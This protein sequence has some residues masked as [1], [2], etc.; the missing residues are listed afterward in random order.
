MPAQPKELDPK[1]QGAV[2]VLD[3]I[4][5]RAVARGASDIHLEPKHD[6][7]V[8]RMRIDGYMVPEQS[9]SADLSPLVTSRVKVLAR[10]DIAERR[11]PQDGQLTLDPDG[12][13]VHLRAS[14][15]PCSQ[16]EKVVLRVL[17]GQKLI[18]FEQLGMDPT[19]MAHVRDILARPQ[20]FLV[21]SGPT[22]AGKTSTLYAFLQQIDTARMNVMTLEDPIEVEIPQITQ[23]QTHARAGFTFAAGL[24]AI[25]RQDPDVILVGEMRDAETA[26]IAL[27]A[28][29]TGHLVMSTL[30]TSDTVETVVRLVDLGLEPWVIANALSCVLAQRLVRVVCDACRGVT[31]LDADLCDG[32]EVLLPAG[33]E[34]IRPHGCAKCFKTGYRGRSGVFEVLVMDDELRDLVK[35]KAPP[36]SYRQALARR[37]LPT[38]RRVAFERVHEGITTVDEV[39]RVT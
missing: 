19:T 21:T 31:R 18:P 39:L 37:R 9:V 26:A 10:M 11:V 12:K 15:F 24:R 23:G 17:M 22:G 3:E 28:S 16:G 33:S 6:R 30:H 20:G 8:V 2:L 5:R 14:T 38:L 35:A 1:E 34:I 25:L 29:L 36:R 27:Q 13:R 7:L 4:V 32:D